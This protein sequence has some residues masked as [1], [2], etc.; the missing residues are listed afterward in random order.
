MAL[1]RVTARIAAVP[2]LLF[3]LTSAASAQEVPSSPTTA[4]APAATAMP[5]MAVD[6]SLDFVPLRTQDDIRYDIEQSRSS[7]LQANAAMNRA[8]EQQ[9]GMKSRVAITQQELKALDSK[10]S[11]AKKEKREPE[12]V[13]LEAEK[14]VT[15]RN[16]AVMER[17]EALRGMEIQLA[18]KEMELAVAS[19]KALELELELAAQR[20]ERAQ[21]G[22]AVGP[23]TEEARLDQ[24]IRELERRTLEAQRTRVG[25]SRQVGER[26]Q[27]LVERRLEL[28]RAEQAATGYGN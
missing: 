24:V 2:A 14:K 18:Q 16:K 21:L 28:L 1:S 17:R 19:R 13:S 6:S 22:G 15:E 7:E 8:K 9:A 25:V 23:A 11:L 26:E 20:S 5:V 3:A 4:V 27:G 10:I 12:R